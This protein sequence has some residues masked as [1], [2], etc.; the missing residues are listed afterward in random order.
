MMFDH[1]N[2]LLHVT[3]VPGTCGMEVDGTYLDLDGCIKLFRDG[4]SFTT[5]DGFVV[6]VDRS[7]VPIRSSN[8]FDCNLKIPVIIEKHP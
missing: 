8:P 2:R 5:S 6:R 1:E 3:L 7:G 4:D